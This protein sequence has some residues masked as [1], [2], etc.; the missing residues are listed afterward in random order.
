MKKLFILTFSLLFSFFCFAQ[1]NLGLPKSKDKKKYSFNLNINFAKK[2][3]KLLAEY[4]YKGEYFNGTEWVW[5]ETSETI[6]DKNVLNPK[7]TN[8]SLQATIGNLIKN[9]NIG[10]NYN[11]NVLISE[12]EQIFTNQY[13]EEIISTTIDQNIYFSLAGVLAYEYEIPKVKYLFL[14]PTVSVGTYQMDQGAFS[15]KGFELFTDYRLDL[16]YKVDG[17]IGF[18][19]FIGLSNFNYNFKE[20]S[21]ILNRMQST[22]SHVNFYKIGLCA[23][24]KFDLIP[25]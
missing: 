20:K 1:E 16:M 24:Y 9:V 23:S 3:L 22:K 13:G 25:D 21:E 8:F 15:G 6:F 14:I 18:G 19:G 10:L 4:D 5:R 17:K 2:P 12:T 7:Y 11:F